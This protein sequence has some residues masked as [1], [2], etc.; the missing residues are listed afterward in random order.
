MRSRI[1]SFVARYPATLDR[2]LV[3]YGWRGLFDLTRF[4]WSVALR[5]FE[6]AQFA[7]ERVGV[8]INPFGHAGWRGAV[9]S[10]A[11]GLVAGRS[12]AGLGG[13]PVRTD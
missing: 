7:H 13:L 11:V 1:G 12:W 8:G 2:I 3:W 4:G 6:P 9:G 10:C 5:P